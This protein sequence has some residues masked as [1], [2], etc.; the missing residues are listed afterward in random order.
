[1][2]L[3]S[4][5][6]PVGLGSAREILASGLVCITLCVCAGCYQPNVKS[7]QLACAD[8][9]TGLCPSGFTCVQGRC[10]GPGARKDGG[11][12]D[13]TAPNSDA[14]LCRRV[15]SLPG[16]T[17]QTTPS[18]ACD[19]VCQTNCGCNQKCSS[20]TE[21]VIGCFPVDLPLAL[22]KPLESCTVSDLNTKTQSDN[23]VPGSFC[24][25]P[26]GYG[27]LGTY[28]FPLCRTAADCPG[29]LACSP[30]RV[31]VGGSPVIVLVCDLPDSDCD[32]TMKTG[33]STGCTNDRPRCYLIAPDSNGNGRSVCEY[34]TG[35]KG[36]DNDCGVPRDCFA[37]LTCPTAD[38]ITR[39]LEVCDPAAAGS[40]TAP[41]MCRPYG[42][43]YGYC[44]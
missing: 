10:E 13:S 2:I 5:V 11:P 37:G 15:P 27:T 3:L 1:M 6:G 28:C 12:R 16:C 32:P 31:G 18:L 25:D 29:G 26:A 9:G 40:C 19:P 42:K 39:C 36:R 21:G 4:R 7:G 24:L 8:G 35:D 30:R 17:A 33:V 34:A 44:L 43:K 23:C 20:S 22:K 14:P 41:T 38:R